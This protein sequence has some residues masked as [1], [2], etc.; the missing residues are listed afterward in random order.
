MSTKGFTDQTIGR[1]WGKV[2]GDA[3]EIQLLE[4]PKGLAQDFFRATDI[5]REIIHGFFAF[6]GLSNCITVFGSARVQQESSY[7]DF[8]RQF[9]K[10]IAHHGLPIMTG[11][12]PG[13]MEAANRGA[14]EAGGVSI[15]C[16]IKL[17]KE[18]EPNSYLDR[19]I[20]FRY[21]FVRKL[22]LIRYSIGFVVLPGGFGTLD[23][24]F[25]ALTLIQTG[26][27]ENFPVILVSRSYW[28]PLIAL[29][30]EKLLANGMVDAIDLRRL[31]VT[32]S[33]QEAVDCVLSCASTRFKVP[34][35]S[36]PSHCRLCDAEEIQAGVKP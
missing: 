8:A 19:W 29:V 3:S 2:S 16:N 36:A 6:R 12:G 5:W 25:E 10:E 21:F 15:G 26:K 30:R 27:I 1:R 13:I 33:V 18:Q 23:E 4:G 20:T 32:D 14:K 31:F 34:L 7:Y 28:E 11:G 35:R 9:G 22:M 24:L 17:P